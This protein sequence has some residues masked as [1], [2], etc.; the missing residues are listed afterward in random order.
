MA[1]LIKILQLEKATIVISQR[2]SEHIRVI[3]ELNV[4]QEVFK[5]TVPLLLNPLIP[6]DASDYQ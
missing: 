5:T 6:A 4:S 1:V 3:S 2:S